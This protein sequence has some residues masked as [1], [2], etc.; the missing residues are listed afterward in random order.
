MQSTSLQNPPLFY[1]VRALTRS[2]VLG[3]LVKHLFIKLTLDKLYQRKLPGIVNLLTR[4][5]GRTRSPP[6]HGYLN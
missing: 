6:T 4:S 3:E 2:V 5:A 1:S